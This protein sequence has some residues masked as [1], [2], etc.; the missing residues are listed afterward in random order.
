MELSQDHSAEILHL[1]RKNGDIR[2]WIISVFSIILNFKRFGSRLFAFEE[3][4][5]LQPVR[6]KII[7]F[8]F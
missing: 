5:D 1:G 7:I 8:K 4:R 2:R 3:G 6:G